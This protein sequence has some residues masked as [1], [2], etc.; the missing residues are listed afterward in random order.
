MDAVII[1]VLH[2]GDI[3]RLCIYSLPKVMASIF[4]TGELMPVIRGQDGA[5]LCAPLLQMWPSVSHGLLL[6]TYPTSCLF[7]GN[8]SPGLGKLV[9]WRVIG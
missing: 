4:E 5:H 7:V 1:W 6:S 3:T 2:E 8:V 9:A